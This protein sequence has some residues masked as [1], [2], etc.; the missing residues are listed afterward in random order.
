MYMKRADLP[1]EN[2]YSDDPINRKA[3]RGDRLTTSPCT[4]IRVVA[5]FNRPWAVNII[6]VYPFHMAGDDW[7][8]ERA[9]K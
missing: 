1:A 7:W 4:S 6:K 2:T 3:I 8:R 5:R 9:T